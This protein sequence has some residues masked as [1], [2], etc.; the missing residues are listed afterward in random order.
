MTTVQYIL[1]P[2]MALLLCVVWLMLLNDKM[3]RIKKQLDSLVSHNKNKLP[4]RGKK[5]VWE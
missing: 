3:N 2:C 4:K 1:L 5:P